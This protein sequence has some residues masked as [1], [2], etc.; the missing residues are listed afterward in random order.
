MVYL[1]DLEEGHGGDTIFRD[2]TA[3]LPPPGEEKKSKRRNKGDSDR[4]KQLNVQP[5]TG[6]ALLFFPSYKDG[7][8]DIRTLHKGDLVKGKDSKMIAQ[9]WIHERGYKAAVPEKNLQSD[10][11]CKVDDE[12]LRLGYFI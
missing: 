8:P 12:A 9:L 1:N 6:N 11:V 5:I 4:N 3:P 10:A 7:T 2:L